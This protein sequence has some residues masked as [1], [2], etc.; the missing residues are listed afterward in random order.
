[1]ALGGGASRR[2]RRFRH[3]AGRGRPSHA[4]RGA[5]GLETRR[6]DRRDRDGSRAGLRRRDRGGRRLLGAD[7]ANL[8]RFGPTADSGVIVGKWSEPG[9]PI[10]GAGTIVK[11]R[12][13]RSQVARTG[14]PARLATDDP[15]VPRGALR[16]ADRAWC[17]VLVAAPIVVSG[18][19]WGAVVVSLTGEQRFPAN[20]EER[21]GAVCGAR[22]SRTR[23]RPG[24]EELATLADEQAALSRVAVAAETTEQPEQLFNIVTEEVGRLFGGHWGID[25][26]VRRG[27]GRGRARRMASQR[28]TTGSTSVRRAFRCGAACCRASVRR[29]VHQGRLR[30]GAARGSGADDRAQ[31]ASRPASRRRSSSPGASGGPSR[32]RWPRRTSSAPAPRRESPSSR[33]SSPSRSPT[34]RRASS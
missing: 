6:G 29:A 31:T 8:V 26:S 17:D 10:P 34:R 11:S 12:W 1:M 4:R 3:A 25:H 7:A 24:P 30:E 13:A 16:A 19:I 27:A 23:E 14:A 21:L 2:V 9:V 33:T 32:S 5:S 28:V 20:A 18:D 22:R 15:G